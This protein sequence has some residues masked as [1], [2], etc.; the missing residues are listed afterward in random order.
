MNSESKAHGKKQVIFTFS[1]CQVR[2]ASTL[3][4]S[5]PRRA[6]F[7]RFSLVSTSI[8][9][10][11]YYAGLCQHLP[12]QCTCVAPHVVCS[13][14]PKASLSPPCCIEYHRRN[15]QTLER[16]EFEN[17]HAQST[18]VVCANSTKDGLGP[19]GHVPIIWLSPGD[20]RTRCIRGALYTADRAGSRPFRWAGWVLQ[21]K[22]W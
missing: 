9:L 7:N 13:I 21:G 20:A 15:L 16:R 22:A 18:M 17:L 2:D 1:A 4:C 5:L 8:L 3:Q 14:S 12:E 6:F 11:S 19:V 10:A